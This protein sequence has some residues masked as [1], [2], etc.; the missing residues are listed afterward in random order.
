MAEMMSKWDHPYRFVDVYGKTWETH[1]GWEPGDPWEDRWVYPEDEGLA[2][3]GWQVVEWVHTYI[4]SP[5]GNG[6]MRLTPE[7]QRFLLWWYAFY[8]ETEMPR[9]REACLVRSKGWG[10][11]PLA[12]VIC[13]VEFV[14]PC[15]LAGWSA[16]GE[17]I[18]GPHWNPLVQLAAVSKEQNQNT[19]SLFP[20]MMDQQFQDLFEVSLGVELSYA[21]KRRCTLKVLTSNYRTQEGARPSCVVENEALALDTPIPTPS[22][23]TAMGDLSDGDE[24]YAVDGSVTTVTKAHPVQTGRRCFEVT[25]DDGT[26]VVASDGH[27]WLTKHS[28]AKEWTRKTTLELYESRSDRHPLPPREPLEALEADLPIDPYV[29]GLW[30]GDGSAR[31]ATIA[32]HSDDL[33]ETLGR[34][35]EAG[36]PSAVQYDEHHIRIAGGRV[37]GRT[38]ESMQSNL[39]LLSLIENKHIPN[40]YLRASEA[41]RWALLQGLMDSDG[42][43]K[44]SGEVR[45][46]GTDPRLVDGVFELAKSLGLNCKAPRWQVRTADRWPGRAHWKPCGFVAIAADAGA[47]VFRLSRKVD[48][49]KPGGTRRRGRAI[50]SITEV[51]SVPVRCLTVEHESHLFLCGEGMYPTSNT[52]HWVF[53]KGGLDFH[54][55]MGRNLNKRGDSDPWARR[56]AISNAYKP[57]EESVARMVRESWED[58]RAGRAVDT[59]TLLYDSIEA[60]A[61]VPLKPP[62]EFWTGT[63]ESGDPSP[64]IEDRIQWLEG[65]LA[66]IRGDSLWLSL[67][68]TAEEILAPQN[69]DSISQSRRFYLNQVTAAEEAWL[70]RADIRAAVHEK[71]A[72]L[73]RNVVSGEIDQFEI[74]WQIVAPDEPVVLF[75]DGS[76]SNDATAIVGCR[77]SDGYVFTVGVWQR[78][79]DLSTEEKDVWRVDRDKVDAQVKRAMARF[80]VVAFFADPSHAKDE[81]DYSPYWDKLLDTWHERWSEDLNVWAVRNTV[82]GHSIMWDM[83]SPQR[84]AQF[85]EA[86]QK[87]V[88]DFE[89]LDIKID[90]HPALLAHLT[91]AQEREDEKNGITLGKESRYSPRKIDLAVCLVGAR[92]L[93][94]IVKLGGHDDSMGGNFWGA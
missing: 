10:K 88:E 5:D 82:G 54:E 35:W 94:R 8:P 2:T 90:G 85:V 29:L 51:A 45:F 9:Y 49:L 83:T 43:V 34:I 42:S 12:A 72:D 46:T 66:E 28:A 37:K 21:Q 59:D 92:M 89:S 22:G 38:G 31:A 77:V 40:L 25:F 78:P 73:R 48:R 13:I 62:E 32:C 61:D 47:P 91:N 23:W 74:G 6:R 41:Q 7:Q 86:A 57:S 67:R 1:P 4:N 16:S 52:H 75:F 55:V 79:S 71:V 15:R 80:N 76:K 19:S 50:V 64:T 68:Q 56:L 65:I 33:H 36:Y 58:A 18:A 11:D 3:I 24:V 63:T 44:K 39:R 60:R 27:K 20:V 53:S 14:G 26:S 17:P 87:T 70:D 84:T 30:L 93:A 81:T 69:Q